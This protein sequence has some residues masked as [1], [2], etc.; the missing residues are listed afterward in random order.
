MPLVYQQNINAHTQLALWEITEPIHFFT[1]KVVQIPSIAHPGKL[2]QHLAG[3]Y[4]L[5]IIDEHFPMDQI[6]TTA[7]GKPVVDH[8]D[9]HFSISHGGNYAAVIV[10]KDRIVGLDLEKITTKAARLSSKFLH[11]TEFTLIN[12]LVKQ[13]NVE[14]GCALDFWMT[15]AWSIK[16]AMFKWYGAT[17]IDFRQHLSIATIEPGKPYFKVYGTVLKETP[18]PVTLA[19]MELHGN[20]LTWTIT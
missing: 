7:N 11:E 20:I 19:G 17:G 12:R 2:L 13:D 6:R 1:D 14:E 16:E 3:R 9:K 15:V 18:V 8:H 4:L 10:S 5:Q